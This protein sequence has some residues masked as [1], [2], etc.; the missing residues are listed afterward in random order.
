MW[1]ACLWPAPPV[2]R[3]FTPTLNSVV[4]VKVLPIVDYLPL[5]S[6]FHI[7]LSARSADLYFLNSLISNLWVLDQLCN[8]MRWLIFR[9]GQKPR[10]KDEQWH[11]PS[12][13]LRRSESIHSIETRSEIWKTDRRHSQGYPDEIRYSSAW[14]QG[15]SGKRSCWQGKI[16]SQRWVTGLNMSILC[17]FCKA[18]IKIRDRQVERAYC[19]THKEGDS[20]TFG[21]TSALNVL[22]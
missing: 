16:Y 6:S 14:D 4:P 22:F 9:R 8:L 12:R 10:E 5:S 15:T 3:N 18:S 2:A 19:S 11:H 7:K 17:D 20:K 13:H 21:V 1:V